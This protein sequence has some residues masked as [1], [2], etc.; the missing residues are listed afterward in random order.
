MKHD[1]GMM[2]MLKRL[3]SKTGGNPE[4]ADMTELIKSIDKG[5]EAKYGGS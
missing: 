2:D 4:A 5:M 1:A 3:A